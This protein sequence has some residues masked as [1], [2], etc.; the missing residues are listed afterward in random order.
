MDNTIDS[1]VW[2]ARRNADMTEGRG[3]MVLDSIW[4]N[5]EIAAEYIDAQPGIMGVNRK[6]STENTGSWEIERI[7]VFTN[8]K[9]MADIKREKLKNQ[10]LQ[11]LSKAEREALGLI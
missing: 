11:K 7:R 10:A 1:Y 6:W 8:V 4:A 2:V 5:E 3:P 9:D